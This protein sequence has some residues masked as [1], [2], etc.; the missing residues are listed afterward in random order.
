MQSLKRPSPASCP[1]SRADMPP[2]GISR[3]RSWPQG[4]PVAAALLVAA[5]LSMGPARAGEQKRSV[6]IPEMFYV[7]TSGEVRDQASEHRARL[8]RFVDTLR[9]DLRSSDGYRVVLVRC[10]YGDCS[11]ERSAEVLEEAKRAGADLVLL[12]G[13][14][15]MSTLVQWMK[16]ELVDVQTGR[17]VLD[18]LITFRGDTDESWSHAEKFL[19]RQIEDGQLADGDGSRRN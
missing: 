14:H 9:Q 16:A 1:A 8:Q 7:D 2:A 17:V 19:T 11:S 15:K 13:I 12:G 6:A 4:G 10:G 18:R 3:R 5:G